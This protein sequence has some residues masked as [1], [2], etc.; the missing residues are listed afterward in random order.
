M[1]HND[2]ELLQAEA[3][4]PLIP[5]GEYEAIITDV[6]RVVYFQRDQFQFVFRLVSQ[7]Q[8]FNVRLKAYCTAP[9]PRPLRTPHFATRKNK[10]HRQHRIPAGSK[11]G[12]WM[13]L[14]AGFTGGNP[15]RIS[16][17][18]FRQYW[19]CVQVETVTHDHRQQ[20]LRLYARYSRVSDLVTIIG[21]LSELPLDRTPHP[22]KEED[23]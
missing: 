8:S 15:S 2:D 19:Y 12:M 20:P 16:L 14:L 7:G 18:E 11:L 17:S 6:K 22:N 23:A 13:A 10:L 4:P 21:K 9:A 5:P 1:R 3:R